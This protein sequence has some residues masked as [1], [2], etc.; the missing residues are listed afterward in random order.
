M[1]FYN[2]LF[3]LLFLLP[4]N[5]Y[6]EL[7][8]A[9]QNSDHEK[10]LYTL[11]TLPSLKKHQMESIFNRIRKIMPEAELIKATKDTVIYRLEV[12]C[13]NNV[14][15]AKQL[16]YNL[17]KICKTPFIVHSENSYCVIAGSQMNYNSAVADQ[18]HFA[19]K[20]ISTSIVKVKVP[21]PQ[22]Q[23]VVANFDTLKDSIYSAN[24]LSTNGIVT[25][26]EPADSKN[27]H[28]KKNVLEQLMSEEIT[29]TLK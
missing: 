22:W 8:S 20:K 15:S 12:E 4:I 1:V 3:L 13:F 18:K 2:T 21:L 5:V 17:L 7:P 14:Q 25:T 6:A 16:Q 11:M 9:T 10:H 28:T 23:I 26:V 29:L 24:N 19:K 27:F